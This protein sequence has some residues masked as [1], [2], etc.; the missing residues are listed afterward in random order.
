MRCL[1]RLRRESL[2]VSFEHLFVALIL[3]LPILTLALFATLETSYFVFFD[4]DSDTLPL[5]I[6]I[7]YSR[8]AE[9]RESSFYLDFLS[10]AFPHRLLE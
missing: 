8:D 5:A 7:K 6:C 9:N 10:H 3:T 1:R 4:C 2:M